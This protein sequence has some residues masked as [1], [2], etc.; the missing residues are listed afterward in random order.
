MYNIKTTNLT[1]KELA[2]ELSLNPQYVRDLARLGSIPA[3]K[4]GTSWRFDLEEVEEQL[5]RNAALAVQRS[6]ISSTST[7]D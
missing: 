2:K 7:D 3:K 1:A 4:I 6:L 5:N